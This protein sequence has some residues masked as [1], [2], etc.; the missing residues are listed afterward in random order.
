MDTSLVS[1][2]A[3]LDMVA[4]MLD[5]NQ[6]LDVALRALDDHRLEGKDRAFSR[7]LAM[8]VLRR[9]HQLDVIL[10]SYLRDPIPD[11]QRDVMHI[12]RLAVIQLLWL[13]TP[14]HAAVHSAVELTKEIGHKKASGLVNAVLNNIVKAGESV[15]Q[16]MDEERLQLPDWLWDSW[17]ARYGEECV[18][19][20]VRMQ[21]ETP[22]LDFYVMGDAQGW[23]EK[24]DGQVVHGQVVRRANASVE[25]LEGY[26]D[27]AWWVQDVAASLPALLLG[28]VS[29]RTVLD[30]CAAPGGKTAQLAM[31]GAQVV[32]IDRS[33]KRMQRLKE[34]MQ[35]LQCEV[36]V[37]VADVMKWQPNKPVDVILLDA[38]CSATGTVRRHPDLLYQKK[39]QDIADMAKIQAAM[40]SHVASWL[41]PGGVL[42]YCVCSLQPEE[43][44]QQVAEFLA[45]HDAMELLPVTGD[46]LPEAWIRDGLL[47]TLPSMLP[48][49]GGMDGFFAARMRKR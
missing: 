21:L 15:L 39:P 27:G 13:K 8:S 24:L 29:G 28:D 20:I 30:V 41:K 46:E 45:Q 22:P 49:R 6:P 9:F 42:I 32:A 16:G 34:N 2:K 19:A 1:R 17:V 31:A 4:C 35:R 43:G 38:P 26:E 3:A 44:E 10:G 47:R 11:K 14:P 25:Q 7:L 37:V 5:R 23:A 33:K 48:D 40:L 36:Q 18:R 12:L